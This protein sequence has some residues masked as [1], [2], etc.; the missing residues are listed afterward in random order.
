MSDLQDALDLHDRIGP[1]AEDHWTVPIVAAARR[2]A[3]PDIEAATAIIYELRYIKDGDEW[4]DKIED[5]TKRAVDASS[6]I[7]KN[8]DA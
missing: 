1:L 7:T 2:V 5:I 3:N 4:D 6:G 8:T